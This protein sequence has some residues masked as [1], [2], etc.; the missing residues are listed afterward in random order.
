MAEEKD[1]KRDFVVKDRR[2]FAEE[3]IAAEEK[4]E[5]ETPATEEKKASDSQKPDEASPIRNRNHHFSFRKLI[6]P[7]LWHH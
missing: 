1:E 7:P 3:N 5:K 6:L 4:E 2:I